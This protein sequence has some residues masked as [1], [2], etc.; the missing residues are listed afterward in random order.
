MFKRI[1]LTAL[2]VTMALILNACGGGSG[3]SG[4]D[5]GQV[6]VILTDG[7]TDQFERIL[8]S[9]TRM[10]L[11]GPG[12]HVDLY[13]GPEAITFDLLEMSEWGDLAFTSKVRAGRYNKIRLELSKVELVDLTDNSVERLNKL[14]ANGKI[15]LNPRGSFN[16]GPDHTTVIQLDMDAERSFQVVQTGS[17]KLLMRPIIFVNIFEDSIYLPDRLVRLAGN[18]QAGSISGAGT[19]D[20][21]DDS[22]RLCDLEFI[23]QS[24]G[25][26]MGDATSC[27]KVYVDASTSLFDD[28]GDVA[29]FTDIS[30]GESL[31]AI[32]F[33]VETDDVEAF[34]GLNSV[35]VELG[36]RQSGSSGGWDTQQGLVADDPVDCDE[37]DQCFN[38][39]PDDTDPMMTVATRMRPETRVFRADGVELNQ[40]DIS[41]GDHGSVDAVLI[42]NELQAALVVLANDASSGIVSGV[43]DSV[44][45]TNPYVLAVMSESGGL[46]NVCI[47]P[48]SGVIL[49]ILVD[50]EAVSILDLLDPTVLEIGSQ[51]EAFG[52]AGPPPAGCDLNAEEI[53]VEAPPVP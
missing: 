17:N 46:F 31:T 29:A 11:I 20:P 40:G 49:H 37:T 52:E 5:T 45:G 18:I 50:D 44:S 33:I 35:V 23:S 1:L 19:A 10:T 53:L 21:A 24:A 34:L 9:M 42:S 38:F 4:P 6:S 12:G 30:D 25:P 28:M 26:S 7:P 32:G 36:P 8:I 14:P 22:F 43:L 27:V 47:D 48:G 3:G 16:V 15:D 2:A 41:T 13:D 39:D 51:I